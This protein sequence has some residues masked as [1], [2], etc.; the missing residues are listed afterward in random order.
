MS[1]S[2]PKV[3]EHNSLDLEGEEIDN[4]DEAPSKSHVD[5]ATPRVGRNTF[6]TTRF[7]LY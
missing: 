5:Q 4:D 6:G 2:K 3:V 7:Y 1:A